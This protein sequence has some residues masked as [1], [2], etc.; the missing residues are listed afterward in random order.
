VLLTV[1]IVLGAR[2]DTTDNFPSLRDCVD[3][4]LQQQLVNVVNRLGLNDATRSG[5]L[6]IALV[7]ITDASAPRL[8]SLNGDDMMYAASLP[9]I[10]ILYAAFVEIQNGRLRFDET[11]RTALTRMIRVSS[12]ADATLMLNRVGKL[13][14]ADILQSRPFRLYDPAMNG[15]LWVGKEYAKGTAYLRDPIHHLSHGATALQTARFYYLLETEQLVA[16]ELAQQMKAML[17][18]PGINH[19]FVK[20]LQNRPNAVIYRKSGTWQQWHADSAL[21]EAE[22]YKYI[23]VALAE[24]PNGGRWLEQLIAPMHDLVVKP[25]YAAL[26]K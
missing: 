12:N 13:R 25:R 5:Q 21:V 24:S 7:D 22:G 9:K 19:K 11:T 4:Y 1:G 17:A 10:A 2:A 23:A 20:G 8:A 3:P 15:G 6:A 26:S 16:P 18:D 14:V